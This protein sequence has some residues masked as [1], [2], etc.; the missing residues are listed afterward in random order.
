MF[1]S[2]QASTSNSDGG[3]DNILTSNEPDEDS[4]LKPLEGS[5]EIVL[6]DNAEVAKKKDSVN[7]VSG[8]T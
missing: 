5:E 7:L 6:S 1:F 8:Q 3:N 4:A 2:Q